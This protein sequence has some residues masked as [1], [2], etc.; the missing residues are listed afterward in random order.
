[1]M[2]FRFDEKYA[3][4]VQR[5]KQKAKEKA[6]FYAKN[7]RSRAENGCWVNPKR[8]SDRNKLSFVVLC[9]LC[10]LLKQQV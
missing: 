7:S 1:M 8:S 4:K 5:S 6:G 9:C 10:C 3:A 2:A